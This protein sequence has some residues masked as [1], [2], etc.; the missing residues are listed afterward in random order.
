MKWDTQVT[1]IEDDSPTPREAFIAQNYPNPFSTR[2]RSTFG[3]N[4]MTTIVYEVPERSEVRLF[5]TDLLGRTV[6]TL[7]SGVREAGRF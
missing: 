4:S 2:R 7:F 1:S 6:A 3:G 5:V